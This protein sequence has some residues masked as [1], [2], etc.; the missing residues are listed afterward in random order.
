MSSVNQEDEFTEVARKRKKRKAISSP[1]LPTLQK[2]CSSEQPP[3]TPVRPKPSTLTNKIPVILSGIDKRFKTWRSVMDQLRQYHPSLKVSQAK[4]LP[5]GDL[6]VIGDSVQDIVILQNENKMKA[7]LGQNVKITLLK[8][9]QINRSQ[10]KS[11]AIKR[12]PTD[13]TDDEFREF[14]NLNKISYA[15]ADRLKSK[16]DGRVLPIF[17]LEISDPD[18]A[19]ALLL[20]NFTCNVTGIVYK[21]EEFRKPVSVMRCFNCQSFG[22]S[23]KNCRSKPKCLICGESHSHKGCPNKEAG[24][25]KCANC[26]GHMLHLIKGVQSIKIRHLGS[27]W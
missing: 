18:E 22:H 12:V 16:K 10:N 15:K 6:L 9:Y 17:Q 13:I 25:P 19:E 26:M 7:A 11:L 24:K 3:E 5:K 23:A 20:Q 21:V 2:T 14:L 1:T 27:M 4:G 8:A